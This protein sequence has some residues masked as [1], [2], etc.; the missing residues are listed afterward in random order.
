M[1]AQAPK[2]IPASWNATKQHP[3]YKPGSKLLLALFANFKVI[4]K[5]NI[6][7]PPYIVSS[8]HMSFMDIPAVIATFPYGVV[9]LA[10]RKY[11]DTWREKMFTIASL[12][13]VTQFSADR[14]AIRS[15]ITVLKDGW[16]MGIAPEGTRSKVKALIPG[17]GG[18]AFVATRANVPIVPVGISGTEKMFHRPRPNV[19]MTIGKPLRFP[20][21]RAT[22]EDLDRYTEQIMC[23][24]A[25]LLPEKYHGAYAGNPLIAEMA[26]IVRP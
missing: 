2:E 3:L 10:A 4:G 25:A 16:I 5:E 17:T 21:G 26:K 7:E 6:P 11:K 8:N 13:W 1:P 20:E 18:T 23:A 19:T 22:G 15:A 24:I 9:G 12:I 14:D